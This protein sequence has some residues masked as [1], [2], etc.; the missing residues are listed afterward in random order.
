MTLLCLLC[1]LGAVDVYD[2][3]LL[4]RR[5]PASAQ[6]AGMMSKHGAVHMALELCSS[7]WCGR[8]CL[9]LP[10]VS[11]LIRAHLLCAQNA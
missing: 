9:N 1:M 7:L 11:R 6:Q 5:T 2:G 4:L 10:S 3:A 8:R